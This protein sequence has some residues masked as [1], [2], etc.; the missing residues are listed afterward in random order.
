VTFCHATV[1]RLNS[2]PDIAR[3]WPEKS[4]ERSITALLVVQINLGVSL[5][6]S[7]ATVL[8]NNEFISRDLFDLN[9]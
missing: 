3:L 1:E 9:Y 5:Q 6:G 8:F 2:H 7:L 4:L